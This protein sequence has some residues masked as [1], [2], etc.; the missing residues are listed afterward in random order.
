MAALAW[1]TVAYKRALIQSKPCPSARLIQQ[2]LKCFRCSGNCRMPESR[3]QLLYQRSGF[4]ATSRLS[5]LCMGRH[6]T[7]WQ[8]ATPGT[9]ALYCCQPA[10]AHQ[11]SLPGLSGHLWVRVAPSFERL[12]RSK[13]G[14]ACAP[15]CSPISKE[16]GVLSVFRKSVPIV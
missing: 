15:V 3:P 5:S 2:E 8:D 12:V 9:V 11:H 16:V 6:F 7:T 10:A 4:P 13:P 1:F 14:L